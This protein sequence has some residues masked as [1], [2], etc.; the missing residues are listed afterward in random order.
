MK[1]SV[2]QWSDARARMELEIQRKKEHLYTAS[3]FET[4]GFVRT[5]WKT[6]NFDPE[7]N[8]LLESSSEEEEYGDEY[9]DEIEEDNATNN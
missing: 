3:N 6:K 2:K 5:N 4:R 7:S 8:P 9:Y 1:Q